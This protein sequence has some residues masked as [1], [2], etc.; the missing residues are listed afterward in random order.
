MHK[1]MKGVPPS[2]EG[3]QI[4]WSTKKPAAGPDLDSKLTQVLSR[5]GF[6]KEVNAINADYR[7]A[8][9]YDVFSGKQSLF[10]LV[11]LL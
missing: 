4:F 9:G 7:F 10:G 11:A 1:K 6:G 2:I 3:D 5:L 8:L